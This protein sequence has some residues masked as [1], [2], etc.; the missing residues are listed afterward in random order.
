VDLD[1]HDSHAA[2]THRQ[3]VHRVLI[4]DIGLLPHIAAQIKPGS[5]YAAQ[6][7][8]LFAIGQKKRDATQV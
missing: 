6:V 5:D 8:V 4:P 7:S 3:V 1:H 2:R